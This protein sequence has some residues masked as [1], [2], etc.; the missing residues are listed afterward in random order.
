MPEAE[1][2]AFLRR[3]GIHEAQLAE[4]RAAAMAA[5]QPPSRRARKAANREKLKV[6]ALERELKRKHKALAEAAALLRTV[7]GGVVGHHV[8]DQPGTRPVLLPVPGRGRVEPQEPAGAPKPMPG[9]P[10]SRAWRRNDGRAK[11]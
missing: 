5:L 9:Y 3:K 1:L 2:G 6:R 8:H 7:A 11:R 10:S 4:W